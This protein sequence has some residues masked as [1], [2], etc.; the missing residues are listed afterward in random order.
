MPS[1][2]RALRFERRLLSFEY[3]DIWDL[4]KAAVVIVVVVQEKIDIDQIAHVR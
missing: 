1:R 4:F 3:R 2:S